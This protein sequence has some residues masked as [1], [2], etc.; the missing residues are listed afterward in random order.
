M[1]DD[2]YDHDGTDFWKG[3]D[4]SA[5]ASPVLGS[6]ATF[7]HIEY[8]PSTSLSFTFKPAQEPPS[9][10]VHSSTVPELVFTHHPTSSSATDTPESH[11]Q[12]LSAVEASEEDDSS[13]WSQYSKVQGSGDSTVPSPR[14]ANGKKPELDD[15][16][17][18][19]L[20]VG[21]DDHTPSVVEVMEYQPTASLR[22]DPYV[23]GSI[24]VEEEFAEEPFG[25]GFDDAFAAKDQ[26]EKAPEVNS[27]VGG[28]GLT[29]HHNVE[30]PEEAP[31]AS[32]A[33]DSGSSESAGSNPLTSE[34]ALEEAMRGI[35][36][37]WKGQNADR[38]VE[39]FLGLVKRAVEP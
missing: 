24:G 15:F 37:L 18:P 5:A 2:S 16:G 12:P 1:Y 29:T 19:L 26:D 22:G 13:Y 6:K 21:E 17:R 32:E 38:T 34:A 28:L 7:S 36:W 9:D 27:M 23:R 10:V 31:L 39:Q 33:S 4:S 8:S 20:E 35:Y 30:Q 3:Y 11:P 14:L 25:R